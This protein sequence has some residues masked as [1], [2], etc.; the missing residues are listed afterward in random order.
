[1]LSD[2]FFFTFFF[3]FPG[4]PNGFP[5]SL[6]RLLGSDQ[7]VR[8]AGKHFVDQHLAGLGLIVLNL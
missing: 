6:P 3:S 2:A 4:W 8:R 7:T 1:M 5:P